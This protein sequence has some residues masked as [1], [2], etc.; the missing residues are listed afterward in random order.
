LREI[1]VK[2]QKLQRLAKKKVVRTNCMADPYGLATK[3][4]FPYATN[5]F[6]TD[7]LICT[8]QLNFWAAELNYRTTKKGSYVKIRTDFSVRFDLQKS[9]AAAAKINSI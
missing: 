2:T 9:T 4:N 7:E 5:Q 3:S 1:S 8:T 6:R